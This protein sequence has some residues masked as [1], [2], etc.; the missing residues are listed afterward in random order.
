MPMFSA[1]SGWIPIIIAIL[2]YLFLCGGKPGRIAVFSVLIAVAIADP[3][4][5]KILKPAIG[6]IRPC[7]QL[8]L[9]VRIFT[10]C[11]GLYSFP[12]NHSANSSAIISA[13]AVF[14]PKSLWVGIPIVIMVGISRI[15]LGVHYPLDVL[16]G[17]IIGAIIGTCVAYSTGAIF[18][19]RNHKE[20]K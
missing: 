1:E 10:D 9:A 19:I 7:H 5:A 16:G 8:G 2:L 18:H 12:S 20:K 17:F 11:A 6:R 15:Y 3:L 4:C 14:Y 13:I